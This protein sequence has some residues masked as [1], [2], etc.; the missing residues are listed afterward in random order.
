MNTVKIKDRPFVRDLATNALLNIDAN[1]LDDFN[2]RR[3]RILAEK[4]EKEETKMRLTKIEQD[5]MV[6][7]SLLNELIQL[8]TGHGN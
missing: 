1:E 6:I 7:Q 8:R 2:R 5:M 3:N 4:K